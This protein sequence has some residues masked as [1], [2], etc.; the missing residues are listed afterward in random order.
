[1][2]NPSSPNSD[3]P[4]SDN[5]TTRR[6]AETVKQTA[7]EDLNEIKTKAREDFDTV[8]REAKS[9]FEHMR[10]EAG[11]YAEE[12]KNYAADQLS[13]IAA[14]FERVGNEM[15]SGEQPW[16]GRYAGDIAHRIEDV[17]DRTRHSS[18]NE[19]VGD[20][21]QF[22][23]QRPGAF[24]ATAALLGFAASRFLTASSSRRRPSQY[25]GSAYRGDPYYGNGQGY[26]T[27]RSGGSNDGE[28]S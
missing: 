12:Q 28:Q 11:S 7:R 17:A 8:K 22:G 5:D 25:S 18:L 19:M 13:G 10:R 26:D 15:Q 23:R 21:E 3:G 9:E 24:L 14:M 2:A 6:E 1:M 20:V 16:A 27:P 4:V